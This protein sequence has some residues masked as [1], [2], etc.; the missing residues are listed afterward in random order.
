[1]SVCVRCGKKRNIF[2]RLFALD[3]E[4]CDECLFDTDQEH[5]RKRVLPVRQQ[6]PGPSA[7]V[8]KPWRL[9]W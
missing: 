6:E 9:H 2:E 1:M 8:H 7:K 5:R 3:D 4:Y